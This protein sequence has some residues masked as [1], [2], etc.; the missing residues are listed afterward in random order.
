M[1]KMALIFLLAL[2]LASCLKVKEFDGYVFWIYKTKKDYSHKV[3]VT[4]NN[5][6][7]QIISAPG[8]QDIDT[9]SKWPVNLANAYLLNGIF[10]GIH[11]AFLSLEKKDY[12][13]W[14]LYPGRDSL[15]KL[16][17]DKD[18]FT[19]FYSFEGDPHEFL[20]DNGFD[21]AK[22]N[23]LIREGRLGKYFNRLK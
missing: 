6:N 12:F 2:I 17:I 18:P 16:I 22:M 1:K 5:D 8:P 11:T 14:P 3:S 20:N 4:L 23:L 15:Y 21:T 10:G 13:N 7:S 9:S 19:E